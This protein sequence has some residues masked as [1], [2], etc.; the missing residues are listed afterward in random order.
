ME[1]ATIEAHPEDTDIQI[2]GQSVFIN[3]RNMG[4]KF[5]GRSHKDGLFGLSTENFDF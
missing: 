5:T 3:V 4:G 1:F 2:R